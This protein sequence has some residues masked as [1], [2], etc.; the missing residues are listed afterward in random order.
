VSASYLASVLVFCVGGAISLIKYILGTPITG[1]PVLDAIVALIIFTNAIFFLYFEIYSETDQQ[2]VER[3]RKVHGMQWILRVVNQTNLT[4]VWFWLDYGLFYCIGSLLLFYLIILIW[5]A[6]VFRNSEY[7][8]SI[9]SNADEL[10]IPYHDA[11]GF[12]AMLTV[13]AFI[14]FFKVSDSGY[15]S[16]DTLTQGYGLDRLMLLVVTFI[17]ILA[18]FVINSYVAIKK[19]PVDIAALMS[20]GRRT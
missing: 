3:L 14:Y 13:A 2:E 17:I 6:L 4:L 19:I 12:V 18:V 20:R 15:V 7:I 8:K 1:M 10:S 11:I 16:N 9:N 5:D